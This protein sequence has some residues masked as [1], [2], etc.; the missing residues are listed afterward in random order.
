M[1]PIEP[2]MTGPYFLAYILF[3]ATLM[4]A[5]LVKAQ[6]LPAT[7]GRCGRRFERKQLGEPVCACRGRD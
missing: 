4:R 6:I 2:D 3:W 7:C 1:L 5:L